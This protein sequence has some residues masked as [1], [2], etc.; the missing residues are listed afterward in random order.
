MKKLL[1]IFLIL[2][3]LT[4]GCNNDD[5]SITPTSTTTTST[6]L[7][8]DDSLIGTWYSS[9]WDCTFFFFSNGKYHEVY[10]F[11]GGSDNHGD[12]YVVD[13]FLYLSDWGYVIEYNIS[14]NSLTLTEL[15]DANP[16]GIW[17]KQ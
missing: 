5:D 8:L 1:Y 17:I 14:G 13:E 4:I 10:H 16:I 7:S 3:I 12:W 6:T 2:S 15:S 11:S 9:G